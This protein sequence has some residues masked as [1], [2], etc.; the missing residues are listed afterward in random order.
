[1]HD[2]RI[3]IRGHDP[4]GDTVLMIRTLARHREQPVRFIYNNEGV[5][6]EQDGQCLLGQTG[7]VF[8]IGIPEAVI[9]LSAC[10]PGSTI[11][12]SRIETDAFARIRPHSPGVAGTPLGSRGTAAA[13]IHIA[14]THV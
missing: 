3:R 7:S 8:E 6:L 12:S 14:I 2:E 11:A 1:M 9:V 4:R 5:I 13:L 10:E